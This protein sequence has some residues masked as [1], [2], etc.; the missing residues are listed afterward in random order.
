MTV[1]AR[2]RVGELDRRAWLAV[3][4][5]GAGTLALGSWLWYSG[6]AKVEGSVAAGFMGVMP[7]S[8]LVLSYVLLG[9]DFRW[10]HLAGFAVVFAGV[11]LISWE[12]TRMSG[13]EG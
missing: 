6:V 5:W 13:N 12:H 10:I 4:W 7:V 2:K 1:A 11:L 9:E 3:V 8:A